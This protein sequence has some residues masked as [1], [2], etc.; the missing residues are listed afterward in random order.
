MCDLA[1][2]P[3][4]FQAICHKVAGVARRAEDHVELIGIDFKNAGGCEHRVGMHV[5]VGGPHVRLPSGYPAAREFA[6][7]HLGLGV[8]RDAESLRVVRGLRVDLPQMV[9][10]GV[11]SF[12]FF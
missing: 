2:G 3:P 1:I 9:E 5:M 10:D 7:L 8:E 6:D 11:G 12:D 4:Q